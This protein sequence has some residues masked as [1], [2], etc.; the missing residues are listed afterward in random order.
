MKKLIAGA[1]LAAL[2]TLSAWSVHAGGA[3]CAFGAKACDASVKK[4]DAC[5]ATLA[6]LNLTEEQKTKVA[7]LQAECKKAGCT[8][9]SSA[10]MMKGLEQV[11]TAEQL[12]Q[13]KTECAKGG[14]SCP[15]TAAPA[16]PAEEKANQ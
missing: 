12:A 2:V 4:A 5:S 16:A 6:K 11:L 8:A 15:M 14:G 1:T 3:C 7:A 9:E 13:C 10:A